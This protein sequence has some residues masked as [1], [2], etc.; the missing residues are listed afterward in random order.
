[1]KLKCTKSN[2]DFFVPGA[3]YNAQKGKCSK[4]SFIRGKGDYIFVLRKVAAGY[5]C[6]GMLCDPEATF[7]VVKPELSPQE[8]KKRRDM[9][10]EICILSVC[11]IVLLIA[12]VMK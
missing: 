11:S 5:R 9:W 1:M 10:I 8:K 3:I 4:A 6:G 7:K 12:G 2:S